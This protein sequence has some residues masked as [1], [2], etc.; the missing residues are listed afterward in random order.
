MIHQPL[1]PDGVHPQISSSLR[2][3]V[4]CLVRPDLFVIYYC[5]FYFFE[6]LISFIGSLDKWHTSVFNAL[7]FIGSLDKC[8]TSV[9][10]ALIK[11]ASIYGRRNPQNK[12]GHTFYESQIQKVQSLRRKLL[13]PFFSLCLL[14][15][16]KKADCVTVGKITFQW[17]QISAIRVQLR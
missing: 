17:L 2:L 15:C 7:I 14:Y 16:F 5:F 8:H 4:L 12:Y 13:V 6:E 11:C 3:L 9:F 1:A 10:N